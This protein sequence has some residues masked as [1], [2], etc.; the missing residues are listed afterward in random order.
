[1]GEVMKS[2]DRDAG[3]KRN[4]WFRIALA[5][6]GVLWFIWLGIEDPGAITV[7]LLAVAILSPVAIMGFHRYVAPWPRSE[8]RRFTAIVLVG[9]LS[10]LLVTPTAILLMAVKTSLHNHAVPDFTRADV[11]DVLYSTPAWALGALMLGAAGA[12]YDRTRAE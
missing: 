8:A 4:R 2:Y 11:I 12:V 9:L 7:L 3:V 5:I 1:M 10:G 6:A